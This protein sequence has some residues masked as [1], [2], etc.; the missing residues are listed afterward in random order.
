MHV[1][2]IEL[3]FNLAESDQV[4]NLILTVGPSSPLLGS[5]CMHTDFAWNAGLTREISASI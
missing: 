3:Q 2:N 5:I 4:S 1:R